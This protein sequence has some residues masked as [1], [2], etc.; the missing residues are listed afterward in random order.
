MEFKSNVPETTIEDV[1]LPSFVSDAV[2][3]GSLKL[4]PTSTETVESPPI[5]LLV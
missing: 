1:R 5:E 2:A 4:P 3:P